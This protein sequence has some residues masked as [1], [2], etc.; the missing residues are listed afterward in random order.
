MNSGW[1]GKATTT[2]DWHP[3]PLRLRLR[4]LASLL[5]LSAGTRPVV[6]ILAVKNLQLA[7]LIDI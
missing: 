4:F 6:E 5:V 3:R 2:P 1:Q 7:A